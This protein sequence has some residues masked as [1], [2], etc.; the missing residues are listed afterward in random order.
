MNNAANPPSADE[1]LLP[2]LSDDAV[3]E[4]RRFLES[5]FAHFEA[6]YRGQITRLYEQA[7][8]LAGTDLEVVTTDED[9]AMQIWT[10]I[11][12]PQLRAEYGMSALEALGGSEGQPA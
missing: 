9:L 3:V 1:R 12:L 8:G 5:I 4:I 7:A 6:R 10:D 11:L 2:R